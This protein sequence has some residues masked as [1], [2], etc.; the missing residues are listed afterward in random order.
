MDGELTPLRLKGAVRCSFGRSE[1]TNL[2]LYKSA[3]HYPGDLREGEAF[4]F[5]SKT[6]DQVIFIFKE[7]TFA[8]GGRA[9]VIDSRRLRLSWGTWDPYM[10]QQYAHAVGLLLIGVKA[11]S[12]KFE[13]TAKK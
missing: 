1:A 2:K 8:R 12:P 6:G 7:R 10:L 3:L 13:R 9:S 11:F 4:L 5:I